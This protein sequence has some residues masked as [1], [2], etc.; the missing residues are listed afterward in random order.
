MIDV[1]VNMGTVDIK[2][3]KGSGLHLMSELCCLVNAVCTG[4]CENEEHSKEMTSRMILMVADALKFGEETKW[5]ADLED[6]ENA[7]F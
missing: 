6:D 2:C 5:G 4:Y 1:K 3:A 7:S